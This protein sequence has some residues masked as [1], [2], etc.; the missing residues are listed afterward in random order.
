MYTYNSILLFIS[1]HLSL[2]YITY[3]IINLLFSPYYHDED[4]AK[5]TLNPTLSSWK[6]KTGTRKTMKCPMCV[7]K[8]SAVAYYCEHL[9]L[10]SHMKHFKCPEN[11]W[12]L[13]CNSIQCLQ[14]HLYR[15]HGE[16]KEEKRQQADAILFSARLL[17]VSN[18]GWINSSQIGVKASTTL[19]G[20]P[21]I[22]S[23][24]LGDVC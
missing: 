13:L 2:F 24:L 11:H 3:C 7:Y 9:K 6:R 12:N 8:C 20:S 10:H 17:L 18:S 4:M 1:S 5:I 16:R 23:I 19:V 22:I 15:Y 21:I 14:T